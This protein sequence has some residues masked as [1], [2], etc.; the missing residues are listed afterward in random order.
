MAISDLVRAVLTA[1]IA[2]LVETQVLIIN[3]VR[4]RDRGDFCRRD[5]SFARR[6]RF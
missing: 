6:R 3:G 2:L 4:A 5:A 1:A